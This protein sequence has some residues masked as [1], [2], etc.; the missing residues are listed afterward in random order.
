MKKLNEIIG[1]ILETVLCEY[2]P[3]TLVCT[4]IILVYLVFSGILK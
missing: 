1:N 2:F 4:I 3:T